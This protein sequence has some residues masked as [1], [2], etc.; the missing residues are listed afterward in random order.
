MCTY[1]NI[2]ER[3][4]ETSSGTRLRFRAKLD[5]E[6]IYIHIYE[7]AHIYMNEWMIERVN[8]PR[9][10]AHLDVRCIYRCMSVHTDINEW[11]I[12]T[13]SGTRLRFRANLDVE[14]M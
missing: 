7:Y 6:Y 8:T 1:I 2:N 12:E 13:S 9:V 11:L 14:Y 3:L 5:V 10:R 4:I